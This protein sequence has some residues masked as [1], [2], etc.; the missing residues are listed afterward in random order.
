MSNLSRFARTGQAKAAVV[1]GTEE[2][3]IDSGPL[4]GCVWSEERT[5]RD[6]ELGGQ[7]VEIVYV[8]TVSSE[9]FRARYP[10]DPQTYVGKDATKN[11]RT[12]TVGDLD[13]GAVTTVITL[14]GEHEAP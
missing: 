6:Y 2:I 1:I 14:R 12:Y 4:L 10:N 8:G 9:V 13:V 3:S 5:S 7:Q 11:T